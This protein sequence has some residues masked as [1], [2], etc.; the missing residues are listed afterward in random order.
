ML[1]AAY[2]LWGLGYLGPSNSFPVKKNI[3]LSATV[4]EHKDIFKTNSSILNVIGI[5]KIFT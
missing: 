4:N 1:R 3:Y 2:F 5:C